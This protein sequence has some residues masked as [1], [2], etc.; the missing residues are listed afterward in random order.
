MPYCIWITRASS[1]AAIRRAE[2]S[3]EL[4]GET[5]DDLLDIFHPSRHPRDGATWLDHPQGKDPWCAIFRHPG[6][7]QVRHVELSLSF[8]SATF[9]RNLGDL[10]DLALQLARALGG[11][12]VFEES[13]G[14][15]VTAENVD[16]LFALDGA[17][18]RGLLDFWREGRQR[19]LVESH[20]PLELP[21]GAIDELTDYFLF[22]LPCA[23]PPP[24]QALARLTPEHLTPHVL[25]HSMVL[26]DRAAGEGA[27][28]VVRTEDTLVVRPYWSSL[29]F[30]TLAREVLAAVD[31]LAAA[32]GA[33]PRYRGEP[34]DPTLRLRV[35]AAARRHGVEFVEQMGLLG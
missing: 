16:Q 19:L 25:S 22:E 21:L 28:R 4:S 14:H 18:V 29:P 35:E 5:L 26:E 30:R 33:G 13:S 27:V 24:L 11:A 7:G 6:A 32:T 31:R 12:R 23:S 9:P 3:P 8:T 2:P 20:A 17:L 10:V 1:Y 34:L 15:E